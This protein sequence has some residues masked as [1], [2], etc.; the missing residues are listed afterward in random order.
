MEISDDESESCDFPQN[1][2]DAVAK[3]SDS[4]GNALKIV[5]NSIKLLANSK[6]ISLPQLKHIKALGCSNDE[7]TAATYRTYLDLCEVRK[8]ESVS[9]HLATEVDH[10]YLKVQKH[11]EAD[12]EIVVPITSTKKVSFKDME[13]FQNLFNSD[14][15]NVAICDS[16]SIV[17]YYKMTIS[18]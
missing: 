15:V 9:Y 10:L 12:E 7:I 2:E 18:K 14:T 1:Q 5:R 4:S 3:S 8:Y 6:F 17:M 11:L 13:K 16:S